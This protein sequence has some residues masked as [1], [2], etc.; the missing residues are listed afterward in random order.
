MVSRGEVP[1]C[2]GEAGKP[3]TCA[4]AGGCSIGE[5]IACR[6]NQQPRAR[7][8]VKALARDQVGGRVCAGLEDDGAN[9][10]A[11][12]ALGIAVAELVLFPP[13][14]L[15]DTWVGD[16]VFDLLCGCP[17]GGPLARWK[18]G[19]PGPPSPPE[20]WTWARL[21]DA[22]LSASANWGRQHCG[23][24]SV[25]ADV[26]QETIFRL[27]IERLRGRGIRKPLAWAR[28]VI[29]S[30]VRDAARGKADGPFPPRIESR[31]TLARDLAALR[32]ARSPEAEAA[33]RELAALV[34]GLLDRLPPPY[35]EIA[36]LQYLLEWSR[37]EIGSWLK[38]WRPVG[39]AGIRRAIRLAHQM[40][41][42]I[43]QGRH[44]GQ[45][46]PGRY[47]PKRNPWF[48]ATPPPLFASI[49]V[50]DRK[51][52]LRFSADGHAPTRGQA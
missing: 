44:P 49:G 2:R 34:P 15:V 33:H 50:E 4:A 5:W 16:L 26:A 43:G 42:A 52:G 20:G 25:S 36:H 30:L 19:G 23:Y 1:P 21:L 35:R 12:V 11:E 45:L 14:R 31:V 32:S 47:D 37:R 6:E 9:A 8:A 18:G 22:L 48:S 51:G 28:T 3:G 29:P 41:G 7:H 46:W 10:V 27:F 13:D 38:T 39:D 17:G 40:L 24:G